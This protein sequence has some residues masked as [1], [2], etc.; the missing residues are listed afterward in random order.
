MISVEDMRKI[1]EQSTIP[2]LQLMENAGRG[3]FLALKEKF[4]NIKDKRILVACYHG[5]NGGDG[6]VAARYL[7]DEAE[8][9]VLFIG[10]ETRFKEEAAANFKRI[11]TNDRIQ[12]LIDPEQTDFNDYD[13][14][15]DALLG[16]GFSGELN[17]SISSAIDEINSSSA[18]KVSI[19]VPSGV[20]V[21]TGLQTKMVNADLIL[22]LHDI[23]K[24]LEKF[25]DKTVVLNIGLSK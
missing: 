19:D 10:D 1:E 5:N 23:K 20:N 21:Q 22:T 8:T 15:V 17:A 3:V 14:I 25:Q 11:E 13:I 18:F 2:K 12:L 6:F 24:G 7:S 9:D 4:P 16:T